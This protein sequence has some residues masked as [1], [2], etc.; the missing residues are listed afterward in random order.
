MIPLSRIA[1]TWLGWIVANSW[2][3]ALLVII[4]AAASL[5][6]QKAPARLRYGLWLLVLVKVFLPPSLT[7]PLGVGSW[8]IGPIAHR[9]GLSRADFGP[10]LIAQPTGVAVA[11]EFALEGTMIDAKTDEPAGSKHSTRIHAARTP[12]IPIAAMFVWGSG[13]LFFWTVVV[14]RYARVARLIREAR[15]FDEGPVRRALEQLAQELRVR[16]PTLFVTPEATSPFLFGVIR[17]RIVLPQALLD[18]LSAVEL[19]AVLTHELVHLR[20]RDTWIGWAQVVAGGLFWFHPL[21]WWANRQLRHERETVCDEA[22][23]RLGQITPEQYSETI[24]HVLTSARGR[25]LAG[26]SLIGVFERGAKLQNRLE[27]VMNYRKVSRQSV[28]LSR[29]ALCA[30]AIVFLPMAPAAVRALAAANASETEASDADPSETKAAKAPA[31]PA[32]P[33]VD[34]TFD[35][36]DTSPQ[37][38]KTIPARGATDVDPATTEISITFDR[39]MGKG[40]SWT[41]AAPLF[42]PVDRTRKAHWVDART[43]VLPVKLEK[44]AYYRVGVNSSS[45]RNFRGADGANALPTAICFATKGATKEVTERLRAPKIVKLSPESDAKEVD[46]AI[47]ELTVTFDIPMGEGLSWT[48]SSPNFPASPDGKQATWSK[49]RLTCTLPVKLEAGHSYQLGINSPLHNNFQS[50]WGVSADPVVYR[51]KT[52]AAK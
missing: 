3:L 16:P 25:S 26:G 47:T 38:T 41:G 8:A 49:D 24:F 21:V 37:I 27:T 6:L 43:C 20:H 36:R 12:A 9:L 34:Q 14:R 35:I 42:P 39:D 46:P 30:F 22:V 31:E 52:R 2:Q 10:T 44:G 28:W 11:D 40:M 50:E 1:T 18:R 51:F 15:P 17:P 23:L 33:P 32:K 7:T 45:N 19:H 29:V 4:A 48:G 5:L 13:M